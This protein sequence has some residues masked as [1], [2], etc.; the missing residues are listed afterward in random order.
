MRA[1]VRDR[2]GSPD[3]MEVRDLPIP[4]VEPDR[5]LI[6]VRAASLNRA[7]WELLTGRPRYIRLAGFGFRRPK[8]HLL[9]TDVAGTVEAV[10]SEVQGFAVGDDVLGD[11]MYH[12]GPGTFAEYVSAPAD[13]PLIHKPAGLSFEVAATLPQAGTLAVA[14]L[15]GLEPGQR[16]LI[17]GAGGGAGTFAI[18]IAKARGAHVT[19]V[20]NGLKLDLMRA[21]GADRVIDYRSERYGPRHGPFDLILDFLAE[22]GVIANRRALAPH[23]AYR[24]IGGSV[25]RLLAATAVGRGLLRFG[26]RWIGVFFARPGRDHLQTLVDLVGDGTITPT[27]TE[28]Y[29]LD[30]AAE[31]FRHLADGTVLGKAVITFD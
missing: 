8:S 22:R 6:R 16:V 12:G 19:A 13:A 18:Q 17:N 28:R 15:R 5:V 23:G 20:D 3:D 4:A 2:Y 10:G 21:L 9:G 7:D 14:G 1:L 25:P 31:G 24:V 11:L 27:L 30:E 26:R 29:S